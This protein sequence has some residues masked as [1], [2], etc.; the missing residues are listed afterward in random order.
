MKTIELE[1]KT[2]ECYDLI[3]EEAAQLYDLMDGPAPDD[4][5]LEQYWEN[6]HFDIISWINYNCLEADTHDLLLATGGPA[7]GVSLVHNAPVFWY[8]DW[9]APKELIQLEGKA[10]DFFEQ[11]FDTL[12]E[13]S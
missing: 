11:I 10:F 7:Y 6:N 13:I 9:F 2:Q 12:E 1:Q 4:P 8:Q 5:D 3:A